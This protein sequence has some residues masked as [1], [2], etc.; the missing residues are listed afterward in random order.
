MDMQLSSVENIFVLDESGNNT[1]R[2][3]NKNNA[4]KKLVCPT[5]VTPRQEVGIKNEHFTVVPVTNLLG[6]LVVV[7][8][9]LKGE[10]LQESWCFG[11]DVFAEEDGFGPGKRYPWRAHLQYK[12]QG[13][14]LHVC[15]KPECLNDI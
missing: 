3:N 8:I 11:L 10:K 5:G 14:P 1:C 2:R 13:D 15:S 9:I 12:W 6:E 4:G 7:L